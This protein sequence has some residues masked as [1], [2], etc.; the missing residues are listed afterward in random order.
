MMKRTVYIE[1]T[2]VSYLTAQPSRDLVI[3]ARQQATRELWEKLSSEFDTFIS[4][5]V[6]QEAGHG[7]PEQAGKRLEAI[8]GIPVLDIGDED[9]M[10]AEAILRAKAIPEEH[11]EDALHVAVAV[12]NGIQVLLTWNF[13]HLNNPFKRVL[14]RTAVEK[15]GYGCPEICSPEELLEEDL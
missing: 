2:V 1:T 8:A 5:M 6:L 11:P 3:A 15:A 12:A 9:R 7:D 14:I 10:L 4:A 13:A